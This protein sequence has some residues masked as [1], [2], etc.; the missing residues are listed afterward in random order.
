MHKSVK[1]QNRNGL[2]PVLG[3]KLFGLNQEPAR[4]NPKPV[5][6]KLVLK[7]VDNKLW[8]PAIKPPVRFKGNRFRFFPVWFMNRFFCA[9]LPFIIR[10]GPVGYILKTII[11]ND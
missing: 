4:F 11:L 6:I 7:P 8:K 2:K 10:N 1:I 5:R 9:S 3:E